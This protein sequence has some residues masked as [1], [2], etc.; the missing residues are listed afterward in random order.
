M[1][2]ALGL[3]TEVPIVSDED[4]RNWLTGLK[5]VSKSVTLDDLDGEK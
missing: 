3:P 5:D 2:E 1:L 4:K